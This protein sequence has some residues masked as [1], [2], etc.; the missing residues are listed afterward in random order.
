MSFLPSLR[1][2]VILKGTT[3]S[4]GSRHH[5]HQQQQFLAPCDFEMVQTSV[6]ACFSWSGNACVTSAHARMHSHYGGRNS[7]GTAE[8]FLLFVF[9]VTMSTILIC[10]SPLVTWLPLCFLGHLLCTYGS[11]LRNKMCQRLFAGPEAKQRGTVCAHTAKL[12]CPSKLGDLIQT[13]YGEHEARD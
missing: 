9:V 7:Q 5:R 8:L 13:S 4:S 12:S 10:I 11:L 6:L 3:V 1:G 2:G